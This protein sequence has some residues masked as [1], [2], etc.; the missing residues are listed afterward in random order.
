MSRKRRGSVDES[1]AVD[2]PWLM[3]ADKRKRMS[4]QRILFLAPAHAVTRIFPQ[5]RDAGFEVAI[6]E[7]LKGA[8]AFVRKSGPGIIFARPSLP[9][10]QV[11]DL[12]AVGADDPDFPPV[13]VV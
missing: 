11:E 3:V 7:N 8:S 1:R 2:L 6:A 12:L 10:F 5:L 4:T 9:G 13:V